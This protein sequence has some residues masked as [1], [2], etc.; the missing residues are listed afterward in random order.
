MRGTGHR[1]NWK[2]AAQEGSQK[3]SHAIETQTHISRSLGAGQRA[4]M[5]KPVLRTLCPQE[6]P[7]YPL[8]GSRVDR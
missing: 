2:D 6:Y 8:L 1:C 7:E 4:Q 5:R 3:G